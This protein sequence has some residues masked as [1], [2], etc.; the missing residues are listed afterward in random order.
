MWRNAKKRRVKM[1][2]LWIGEWVSLVGGL[3]AHPLLLPIYFSN[4][5]HF[6]GKNGQNNRLL[7]PP[8]EYAPP[9][10]KTWIHWVW[11]ISSC[12]VVQTSLYCFQVS[13]A[14]PT[15]RFIESF[16]LIT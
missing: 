6:R 10:E 13:V 8:L 7:P 12:H 11:N 4:F 16:G 14:V 2:Y 1:E 5:M 3:L 15:W 9:Y